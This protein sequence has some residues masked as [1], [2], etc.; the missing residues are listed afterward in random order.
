MG[1]HSRLQNSVQYL[2]GVGP[3]RAERLEKLGIR[4]GRDLLYHVPRRYEDATRVDRIGALRSGDDATIIGEVVAKGVLPTRK[5]LR[6]FRA[7]VRDDSG[8]MEVA[9]PGQPWLDRQISRGD[10]IL[11]TGSVGFFHGLQLKPREHTVLAREGEAEA[12]LVFPV[13]PATEGLSHRQIRKI[14]EEN[15]EPL[16]EEVAE[17]EVFPADWLSALDLPRLEA[18]LEASHRPQ[19]L[20]AVERAQRRL[21]WEELFFLQLLH[22]RARHAIRSRQQG[23]AMRGPPVLSARFLDALPFRLT[24][25]QARAWSEIEADMGEDARMYRLLQGDVGS[26]KTVVAVT[27]M[28]KAVEN[29][30]QAALMAPTEL[31]AE[32]HLRTLGRLL[33]P[34][35]ES[36]RLLT[37]SVTGREREEI[38]GGLSDGS[39]RLVVGTHA[40]FQEG[41]SLARPGLMV[42]DEQHRFGVSQRRALQALGGAADMLVMSAT[43]IPRSL[44]LT[45][46][47]DLDL[48]VIDTLPPGRR[49]VR[50][51]VRGYA[52]R[53]AALEWIRG[54]L[55]AGRQAYFVYPLIEESEQVDA[56][57]VTAA[58]EELRAT[59]A[60]WNVEMVHGRM[61]A[62]EKESVMRRFAG[63][64]ISVL[65]ATTVIEVGID[66]P[67]ATVMVI[68]HAERF[69]LSQLHQ[70]RGRVGRGGEQS[71]C[72]AFHGGREVP[73]RLQA[74]AAT[75]DGFRL[76]REDLKLRGQGDLF[77]AQQHG[78]PELKFADLERDSD[79]LEH[80]REKA[81]A[82]VASDPELVARAHRAF[83][84][85][86]A[87]RYADREVLFGIG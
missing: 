5:G 13:Y 42:I 18:A 21:A 44:A 16:L 3:R 61:A 35:G 24:G 52:D 39:I 64:E 80:A 2:K 59:Y 53:D 71:W 77:G 19:D 58:V 81:R 32:Q 74:F 69:G 62:A 12:G 65:V 67:N 72:V 76:A 83:G 20:L 38:L 17:R 10:L 25:S 86:L 26:G 68:E 33:A 22:A 79:L 8:R 50:T 36:V 60:G 15:L 87:E 9:W 37:G 49:A 51:G 55:E 14:V 45:L 11:V 34:V 56:K 4:T 27:A 84:R 85:E 23:V 47:G 30:Y 46:Y 31:L 40:L 48:S 28:L 73:P 43:P 75:T 41:V 63:G 7:V 1:T 82:I 78:V 29:G 57:A 54:E 66:V 6:I 70:L